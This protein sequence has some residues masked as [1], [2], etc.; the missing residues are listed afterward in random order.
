L[1]L[2]IGLHEGIVISMAHGYHQATGKPAFVNVHAIVGTAQMSG[3]LYNAHRDRAGIVVTAGLVDPALRCDDVDLAPRPGSDQVDVI[4]PFTKLSWEVR[5]AASIPPA[6]RRAFKFAAT[7]PTGPVYVAFAD[8]AL[9]KP[10]VTAEVFD[11]PPVPS[12]PSVRPDTTQVE[13]AARWLIEG[14]QPLLVV[15]PQLQAAGAVAQAVELAGLLGVPVTDW[16]GYFFRGSGFPTQYPLFYHKKTLMQALRS[17]GSTP[18]AQCDVVLGLGLDSALPD[19]A[20]PASTPWPPKNAKH[21]T[22]GL[23]ANERDRVRPIDL[24]VIAD[25]NDALADLLDAV[26]SLATPDRFARIRAARYDALTAEV[27]G[28]RRQAEAQVQRCCGRHPMHPDEVAMLVEQRLDPEAITVHENFSHDASSVSGVL[29]RYGSGAKMRVANSGS[30]LGWGVGAAIGAK[31]GQPNRQ[32]VLHIG[33][34]ATMFSAAGFWTMA[35]YEVPVLTLIWN[36]LNYQTVRQNFAAYRGNMAQTGHYAGMYLGDPAIDFVQLAR[37]QG[38]EGERATTPDDLRA[39]LERGI[40]V[41][42]EGAPYLVEVL[43]SPTGP[44]AESTWHQAFSLARCRQR[45]V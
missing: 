33:D 25:V 16:T 30:S 14:A 12:R 36:N 44:G 40:A 11:Y 13:Q 23:D 21:V 31:L 19:D 41:T 8:Y 35:R 22:I 18:L 39:A 17:P 10:G 45:K 6:L 9:S 29:L 5:D 20:G 38:V 2:I 34:G 4:K 37:S 28:Y 1:P 7:P 32:V 26:R 43:V 42:Q 15:G 27:A 24:T 3:Q